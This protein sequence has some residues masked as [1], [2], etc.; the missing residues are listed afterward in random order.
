LTQLDNFKKFE[1]DKYNKQRSFLTTNQKII[2]VLQLK[3]NTTGQFYLFLKVSEVLSSTKKMII[4]FVEDPTGALDLL[5]YK[6]DDSESPFIPSSY[7]LFRIEVKEDERNKK[8]SYRIKEYSPVGYYN[9]LKVTTGVPSYGALISDVHVG[10]I[11]FMKKEFTSFLKFLNQEEEIKYLFIAGDLVDGVGIYPEQ[12]KNLYQKNAYLQYEEVF[13]LFNQNITR[14]DLTVYFSPGNHDF[15]SIFEPQVISKRISEILPKEWILLKN[16]DYFTVE[17]KR[18][19]V[20]HGRG[21]DSLIAA[22]TP[23]LSYEEMQKVY[24][25]MFSQRNLSPTISGSRMDIKKTIGMI[26]EIPDYFISGHVHKWCYAL[27]NGVVF[28]NSGCWQHETEYQK[29][30]DLTV[31]KGIAQIINL[32]DP[33]GPSYKVDFKKEKIEKEYIKPLLDF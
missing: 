3:E 1:I 23:E 18:V 25:Y 7:F 8:T 24:D 21:S 15:L 14:K 5:Y 13:K 6:K 32:S 26:D 12:E 19:L 27:K 11:Y 20:Y 33:R 29:S 4:L 10:S 17:G 22:K 2:S 30:L 31:C 28:S 9:S 16:P